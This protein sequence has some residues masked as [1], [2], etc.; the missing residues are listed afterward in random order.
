RCYRDWS[1]DVCSSDLKASSVRGVGISARSSAS[2]VSSLSLHV[3][4]TDAE[5]NTG[6]PQ[7]SRTARTARPCD[8]LTLRQMTASYP[9][10]RSSRSEERRVGKEGR[11]EE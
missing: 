6:M 9:Y 8:W 5:L 3:A 10:Q 4:V 1:S 7:C 11:I 2:V